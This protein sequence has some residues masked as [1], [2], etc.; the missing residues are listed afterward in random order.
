MIA[1]ILLSSMAFAGVPHVTCPV[2][3]VIYDGAESCPGQCVPVPQG[4]NVRIIK[5]QA[6]V[7]SE[8]ASK[9]SAHQAKL[10]LEVEER[11]ARRD[12]IAALKASTNPE[13]R[14]LVELLTKKDK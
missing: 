6:G 2:T 9:K 8:D 1:L 5:C 12:A 10:A 4:T 14:A 13:I 7:I 3:N 11:D